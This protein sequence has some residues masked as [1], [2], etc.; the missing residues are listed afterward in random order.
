MHDRST[1]SASRFQVASSRPRLWFADIAGEDL[2]MLGGQLAELA[3]AG[4][5][6][7]VEGL[8]EPGAA[9][10]LVAPADDRDQ[11]AAGLGEPF[12]AIPAPGIV[13]ASRW[14]R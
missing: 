6:A 13:R 1:L 3:A 2:E 9:P 4:G 12:A 8:L 11:R 5:I 10:R 7:A 14:R